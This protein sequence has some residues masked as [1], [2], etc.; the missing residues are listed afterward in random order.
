[1]GNSTDLAGGRGH[2]AAHAGQLATSALMEPR[3]PESVIMRMGL[4]L[5]SVGQN[6]LVTLALVALFQMSMTRV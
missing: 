5:S 6:C 3:A 4:N 1:M 2:Q